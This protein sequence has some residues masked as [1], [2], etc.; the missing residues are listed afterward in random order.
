MGLVAAV[1]PNDELAAA[2]A[3]SSSIGSCSLPRTAVAE[4][5]ALLLQ[6]ADRSQAEQ[7][8]AERD[9]QYRQFRLL[10]GYDDADPSSS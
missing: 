9:A 6:A 7:E 3:N 4:I 10:A 5:K 8:Q 2:R 1:V